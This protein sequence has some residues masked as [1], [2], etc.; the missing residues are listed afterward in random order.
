MLAMTSRSSTNEE[1]SI[2][3]HC[4]TGTPSY[5][6][7]IYEIVCDDE[8]EEFWT[9]VAFWS[10]NGFDV[11][12]VVDFDSDGDT[13]ILIFNW[14]GLILLEN[15]GSHSLSYIII[16]TVHYAE[17]IKT[18]DYNNDNIMDLIGYDYSNDI[19]NRFLIAF[20]NCDMPVL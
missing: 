17:N 3:V 20:I 15:T 2:Y 12:D 8:A 18:I 19:S 5:D 4:N 6:D 16:D 11:H 14:D 13:D 10:T 7:L 9:Y 1:S